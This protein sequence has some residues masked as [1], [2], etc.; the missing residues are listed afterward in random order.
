M[1]LAP[2]LT[3]A[4]IDTVSR[5]ARHLPGRRAWIPT[6]VLTAGSL[7]AGAV[8]SFAVVRPLDELGTYV[9][10]ARAAQIQSCLDTIPPDAS[11]SATSRL[12]PHLSDRR[13]IY[14]IPNGLHSEFLVIDLST[15]QAILT[16]S[17][18]EYLRGLVR[19]SLA[20][21]YGV[22]CSRGSTVVLQR[23]REQGTL[24]PEMARFVAA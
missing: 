11:V 19:T 22:E 13:Q 10:G 21:G 8:L 17:Y 4:A 18:A 3:F 6:A 2:I 12:V 16:Q 9:S 24:S 5:I 7:A 14:V 15:D 20:S 1:V 23:G